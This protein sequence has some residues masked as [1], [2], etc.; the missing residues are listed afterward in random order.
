M[1]K[2]F[3]ARDRQIKTMCIFYTSHDRNIKDVTTY[4]KQLYNKSLFMNI[5]FLRTSSIKSSSFLIASIVYR[6]FLKLFSVIV[7]FSSMF[8]VKV[9][10]QFS[11]RGPKRGNATMTT[12][13]IMAW[14]KGDPQRYVE[15]EKGESVDLFLQFLRYLGIA[16]VL[17]C[18]WSLSGRCLA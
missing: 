7:Y 1:K 17:P 3:P 2:Q 15:G 18:V 13:T 4:K 9:Q 16:I 11:R 8:K 5:L 6:I 12:S 14:R 10:Q